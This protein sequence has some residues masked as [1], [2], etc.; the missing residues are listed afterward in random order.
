MI[1][2]R[3]CYTMETGYTS[4]DF[5]FY[6]KNPNSLEIGRTE[7]RELQVKAG[8]EKWYQVD[9]YT[10]YWASG[11]GS[12]RVLVLVNDKGEQIETCYF[13]WRRITTEHELALKEKTQY[14]NFY[15]ALAECGKLCPAGASRWFNEAVLE[16]F[17]NAFEE[18]LY[19]GE[20]DV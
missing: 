3:P 14:N 11:H 4:S 17:D 9:T 13:G 18:I 19:Y 6:R 12:D 10:H 7:I 1:D 2:K 16:N 20:D 15:A 8:R 5:S